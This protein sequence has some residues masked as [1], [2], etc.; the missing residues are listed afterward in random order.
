MIPIL[1]GLFAPDGNTEG[2]VEESLAFYVEALGGNAL[3]RRGE[4]MTANAQRTNVR[5]A[6]KAL[7]DLARDHQIIVSHGNG[8]QV[9]LLALQ[10]AA[11]DADTP[12]PLD[13]LGAETE[14]RIGSLIVQELMNALPKSAQRSPLVRRVE[15]APNDPAFEPPSKP[16]GPVYSATKAALATSD[17]GWDMVK[18]AKGGMRRVVRSPLPLRI[19]GLTATQVLLEA[20]HIVICA[21]GGGIPV[22]RHSKGVMKAVGAVIDRDRMAALLAPELKTDAVPL[23]TDVDAVCRNCGKANRWRWVAPRPARYR[24][25]TLPRDLWV[26]KW[27]PPVT[28]CATAMALRG[29]VVC[30]TPAPFWKAWQRRG[31]RRTPPIAT[32]P[33]PLRHNHLQISVRT[34]LYQC[35]SMTAVRQSDEFTGCR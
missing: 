20:G 6:A 33:R 23:L 10:G 9:G 14:G 27:P 11:Y 31:F 3:L 29:L 19:I 21:G 26:R 28:S 25:C 24:P 12:W 35:G 15:V 1:M 30:K 16:V 4:P 22:M 7:A 5:I 32:S 8:P 2:R 13:V 34:N 18:E 17:H